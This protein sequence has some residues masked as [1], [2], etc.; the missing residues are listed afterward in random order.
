MEITDPSPAPPYAFSPPDGF[1]VVPSDFYTYSPDRAGG[2]AIYG[3]L[4]HFLDLNPGKG[5]LFVLIEPT[6]CLAAD[7]LTL[8]EAPIGAKVM[9]PAGFELRKLIRKAVDPTKVGE[10]WMRPTQKVA[11]ENG[12]YMWFWDVRYGAIHSR[13]LVESK[14]T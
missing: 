9:V 6:L 10:I 2:R 3:I 13:Q 12:D 4:L 5:L 11:L 1:Q 14:I 8:V 7:G